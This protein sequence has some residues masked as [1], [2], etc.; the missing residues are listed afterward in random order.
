MTRYTAGEDVGLGV[1]V[2]PAGSIE[3]T[4]PNQRLIFASSVFVHVTTGDGTDIVS[5]E[6]H[7]TRNDIAAA[8][9]SGRR[10]SGGVIG[11]KTAAPWMQERRQLHD[12]DRRRADVVRRDGPAVPQAG[13]AAADFAPCIFSITSDGTGGKHHPGLCARRGPAPPHLILTLT[14]SGNVRPAPQGPGALVSRCL[15]PF[16]LVPY[17]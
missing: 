4:C 5:L 13:G 6:T 2:V 1:S 15:H 8:P 9:S 7:I 10:R 3:I 12:A 16:G 17:R 11:L 14:T